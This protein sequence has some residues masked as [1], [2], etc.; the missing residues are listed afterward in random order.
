VILTVT[1]NA[2]LDVTYRVPELLP[3]ATHRVDGVVARAGGKGVNVAR[4]LRALS[5]EALVTGLAGGTTGAAIRQDLASSGL[6]DELVP[7]AGEAR[8]TVT[9][10]DAAGGTA[11]VFNE[12][13]AAVTADEWAEFLAVYRDLVGRAAVVVLSGSLPPGVPQDAYAQLIRLAAGTTTILDTS[14]R[15]L[16]AGLPS[17]PDVIKPNADELGVAGANTPMDA[18]IRLRQAGAGAVVASLGPAGLL[19]VTGDGA[20]RATPPEPVVGNPTGAGDACVAA[21]A[22]GLATGTP[23]PGV[24]VE[25]V[26]VSAAAVAAPVAGDIDPSAYRRLLP[27]IVV[28]EL[29]AHAD[30]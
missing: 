18:A 10:V 16:L 8:R 12:P 28:K 21:L 27:A 20:W 11:T 9:V 19:A 4:V 13:G 15:P 7:I 2:A 3:G 25:A 26:A 5:H 14:G 29:H 6:P 22:A 1:L 23:W 17:G 24:L 30:R